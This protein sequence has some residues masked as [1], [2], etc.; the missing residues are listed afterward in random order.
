VRD[1]LAHGADRHFPVH[2]EKQRSAR[3]QRDRRN[4]LRIVRQLSVDRRIDREYCTV[5]YHQRVAIGLRVAEGRGRN[6]AI[7]ARPVL[8][9]D[10]LA[11]P[12]L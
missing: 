3:Q 8:D 4:V 2:S 6:A 7:R 10:R 1:E 9:Y 11:K 5:G 12:V